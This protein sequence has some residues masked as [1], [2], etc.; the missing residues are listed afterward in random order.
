M[1]VTP[2]EPKRLLPGDAEALKH[3]F[4]VV[5]PDE[6]SRNKSHIADYTES[7]VGELAERLRIEAAHDPD[8]SLGPK[9]E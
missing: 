5:T 3:G 8:V 7:P 2:G 9:Q 6:L 4:H 1:K